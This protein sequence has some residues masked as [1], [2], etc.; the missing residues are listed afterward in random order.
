M[1]EST[2]DVATQLGDEL[3]LE[4]ADDYLRRC[5]AGEQLTVDE[6]VSKHPELADR[7]RELFPAMIAMEQ[8]GPGATADLAPPT[9]RVGAIIGRY[10]LLERIGEGG[11]GVVYMAEQQQPVRR[12]VALKI[13]KPGMD[14]HQVLA[15][16]E[17]ERQ[18]L[19][20]MD[21]PNIAKVFDAGATDSGRPYFVME[22]VKGEPI[23]DFCDRNRFSPNE[24]LE[25]FD[26]VCH[27][28]QHA[29][30][31]GIIHRD[32][33]PT[34]VLAGMHDTTPAVK[35]IDFGVA[36]ALGQELT[37][38]T[39]FTGFAQFLGTPLYMSPE[40]AGQSVLDVDTRSDVY[41]LGVLLYE[42]LTGTTPF[43]KDR[44][45]Q[46]A[47]DEIFR[48]I[49]D[50][51]PPTPSTRLSSLSLA[52]AARERAGV[53]VSSSLA[54]I[55]AQ[56]QMEP[57]KL[58]K[59]VR[60]ELDWIV[61]KALE[62]DRTR[63]YET[64]TGM[65]RDI[66]RYLHDEPVEAC[67]P[68]ASYRFKKFVRRNKAKLATASL[69]GLAL[70]CVV[71]S[72]SWAA[73]DRAVR[74]MMASRQV[75]SILTNVDQL[76]RERKWPEALAAAR[77]AEAVVTGGDADAATAQHLRERLKDLEFIDRL[78]QVRI[79]EATALT[80]GNFD[81]DGVDRA[82]TRAFREYG[83]D[84]ESLAVEHSIER[85]KA[86][87][88]IVIPVAAALD[89]WAQEHSNGK[90]NAAG[91]KRLVDIAR[92]I[93][94]EPVRDRLRSTWGKPPSEV[95]EQLSELAES[96][97]IR[98]H[99][100]ATLLRLAQRLEQ[101]ERAD[102]AARLR[103]DAQDVYPG[104]FWL[105]YRLA[106]QLKQTD[107]EGAA[108]FYTAAVA[109]RPNVARARYGLGDVLK[110]QKKLDEAIAAFR[111]AIEIDPEFN[112]AYSYL[113]EVLRIQGKLDE[114]IAAHR[115]AIEIDP[116]YANAYVMLGWTLNDQGKMDEVIA[117]YRK[118]IEIEP[119]WSV[120]HNNI[121]WMLSTCSDLK[122]RDTE[123]ALTHA[124]KALELDSSNPFSFA[125]LG[126]AQYRN[127][128][129]KAAIAA[130]ERLME[131]RKG[132]VWGGGFF[133]AM[134]HWQLGNKDEA[135]RCYEK[136]VEKMGEPAGPGDTTS[137]EERNRIRAEAA[138][139][140]GVSEK[141]ESEPSSTPTQ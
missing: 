120:P 118:A 76:E 45:K 51:E 71:G 77:R 39:L 53:R 101:V 104:D 18:A 41:S 68:S 111:K 92:G 40:Q 100:P 60:G 140:L 91:V 33:K 26:Q 29:H 9:E 119:K 88:P 63:R 89:A 14:S 137:D 138:E 96:I 103:R 117:T 66:E 34:N 114:S 67:P 80:A 121:A 97:D 44:F 20:I 28:V 74:Q 136:E 127:G 36:K 46:A 131:L 79:V 61:M 37:D 32:I 21:H 139:L 35:V 52:A 116:M 70:L 141:K 25:L 133:L 75:E 98:A 55:S 82:Y 3:L 50:E 87:P 122:F 12:K 4:L 106:Q 95:R 6:Y 109:I 59:L 83:V 115:K 69:I 110:Q 1:S 56:R 129:Y 72:L 90:K 73:R 23:T 49:R 128:D 86:S 78:E 48:I 17:A 65:A 126:V 30:Q 7:I 43:D 99:D 42:L 19:A 105:N 112:F 62:K 134:S 5:R 113:G 94:P 57:A 130:L 84:V 64:A 10:K 132:G 27:A 54:S 123:M 31:K 58:T 85:L 108:R 135:R 24:R 8:S 107:L 124:K 2:P 47:K 15:R 11:F 102:L 22:L 81:H 93:D 16:F 38:K 13:V 125:G